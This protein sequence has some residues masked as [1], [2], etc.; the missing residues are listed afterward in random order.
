MKTLREEIQTKLLTNEKFSYEEIIDIFHSIEKTL[1]F[2]YKI[3]IFPSFITI[4]N[5]CYVIISFKNKL[6]ITITGS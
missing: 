2:L 1:N 6:K 4:D 5:I 3:Q